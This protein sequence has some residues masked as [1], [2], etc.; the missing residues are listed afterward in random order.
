[1][2]PETQVGATTT[3]VV[4]VRP[5]AGGG[6]S[7]GVL[8][9][10]R[11]SI[12][13]A[14]VLMV[15]ATVAVGRFLTAGTDAAALE[16]RPV[17]ITLDATITTL[18]GAVATYP[19]DGRS[20]QKLGQAY[21]QKLVQ[22]ANPAYADLAR[23]TLDQADSIL[24]D[25]VATMVT[26]AQLALTLH[27]F[28]DARMLGERAHDVATSNN[29]SL[30]VLVDANIELGRYAEAA[31]DLQELLDRKPGL[32][33]L[34]RVSY[35]RE[36]HGDVDGALLA[37]RE[38]QTAA[39]GASAYDIATVEAIRGDLLYNHGRLDE[40]MT[41][42][43]DALTRS[44]GQL[45]ATAGRARVLV[46]HGD[47]AGA[48]ALLAPVAERLPTPALVT[49]LGDIAQ[50]DGRNS[51][52][53]R[54]FELVRATTA[55]QQASGAAVDLEAA[56]FEADHGGD[57]KVVLDLANRGYAERPSIHGADAIAWARYRNGDFAGASDAIAEALQLGTIDASLLFHAAAIHAAAGDPE[58]ARVE[59]RDAL[60]A[61]PWFA[62]GNRR[63]VI[64]LANRLGVDTP[65]AWGPR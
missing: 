62:I 21:V 42:Y 57:P 14:L 49:L 10:H 15:V 53:Q 13:V 25:D 31:T 1:M 32:A 50:L 17:A 44:P 5:A 61:N 56:L 58:H 27:Q 28:A 35:L 64:G 24:A 65:Q 2:H 18:E 30:V 41:A 8:T 45:V 33:A 38:A 55:L 36:L 63:E 29:D 48:T 7:R 60:A 4:R 3:G 12:A 52:A 40:A 20:W 22:S 39:V 9:R 34:S 16:P 43:D 47:L 23:R 46:A 6:A 54:S 59:L 51:D 19:D 26:R 37:L 11:G